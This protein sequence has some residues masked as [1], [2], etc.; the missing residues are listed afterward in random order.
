MFLECTNHRQQNKYYNAKGLKE[1][2]PEDAI[3]EFR[4]IIDLRNSSYDE[5]SA[6]WIFKSLKQIMKVNFHAGNFPQVLHYLNQLVS[7]VPHVNRNYAEESLSKILNNYSLSN[8][9]QF[10]SQLY[11]IILGFLGDTSGGSNDRLW[12][13]IN[14]NKLKNLLE[15]KELSGCFP[16]ITSIKD[17]LKS[18]SESIRNSFSLEVIAA[19]IEYYSQQPTLDLVKLN[20]L[21]CKSSTITSAVTHPRIMGIIRECG[22]TVQFYRGN[23]EKARL[24]YYECFKNYDEA[25]SSSKKKILK[26]L[27]LCSLLTENEVNPF[28]SQ[29]TQSYS[30]LPEYF[31]LISLVKAYDEL[32]LVNFNKVKLEMK[33]CNDELVNDK[34]FIHASTQ[35]LKNLK[36]KI[37]VNYLKSYKTIKFEFLTRKLE[38]NQNELEDILIQLA[39]LGKI[40]KVKLDFINN[41]IEMEESHNRSIFPANLDAKQVYSNMK[42]LDAINLDRNSDP[43]LMVGVFNDSMEIDGESTLGTTASLFDKDGGG[44]VLSKESIVNR[45][46]FLNK[47]NTNPSGCLR[48]IELWLKYLISAVPAQVTDELSQKDQIFSEQRAENVEGAGETAANDNENEAAIQNTNNGILGNALSVSGH[49][50]HDEEEEELNVDKLDALRNWTKELQGHHEKLVSGY[51]GK[52]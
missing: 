9:T 1:D 38:V 8:D 17:K 36:S 32:N 46:L 52:Y 24:E 18:S 4:S 31:N 44:T 51:F 6:E 39:N 16:L 50:Y 7:F 20:Q 26:Y 28:E 19:E 27:T 43:A 11:D 15:E 10:V 5:D 3:K 29:E 13:K 14:L 41:Y 42:M 22:A 47:D 35:I 23:Y 30:Q 21:H 12:L 45:F 2:N 48:N 40:S 33:K 34:I 25:G 49:E 37:L